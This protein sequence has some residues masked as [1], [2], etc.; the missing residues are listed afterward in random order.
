MIFAIMDKG[1]FW[2]EKCNKL[3]MIYYD[4]GLL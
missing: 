2:K 4:C 3:F 1:Q